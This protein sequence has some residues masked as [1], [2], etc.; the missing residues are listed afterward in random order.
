MHRINAAAPTTA[1]THITILG[2]STAKQVS[3]SLQ[4]CH[5]FL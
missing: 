4:E 2:N 5:R 3:F 1:M